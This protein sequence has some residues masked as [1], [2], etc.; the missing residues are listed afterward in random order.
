MQ[1]APIIPITLI[2]PITPIIPITPITPI[3]ARAARTPL[4]PLLSPIAYPLFPIPSYLLPYKL[5]GAT[6]EQPWNKPLI[7][8]FA[9]LPILHYLCPRY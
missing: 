2:T 7:D 3:I 5:L 9:N 6:L 1:L 8:K 4:L